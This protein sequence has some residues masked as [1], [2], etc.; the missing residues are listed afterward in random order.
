M[1]KLAEALQRVKQERQIESDYELARIIGVHPSTLTKIWKDQRGIGN[2]VLSKIM[3]K[4]PE[5]TLD[6]MAYMKERGNKT[7]S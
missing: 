3:A 7:S 5:L 4:I 6:A 2:D 1:N